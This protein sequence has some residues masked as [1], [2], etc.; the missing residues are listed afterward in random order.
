LPAISKNRYCRTPRHNCAPAYAL[1]RLRVYIG[2][3]HVLPQV[4][5]RYGQSGYAADVSS[6]Q[7][8]NYGSTGGGQSWYDASTHVSACFNELLVLTFTHCHCIIIEPVFLSVSLSV[9][10]CLSCLEMTDEY[11][12]F[13]SH[14]LTPSPSAALSLCAPVS[15]STGSAHFRSGALTADDTA[16]LVSHAGTHAGTHARTHTHTHTHTHTLTLRRRQRTATERRTLRRR[17]RRRRPSY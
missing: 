3:P 15:P 4:F 12:T 10:A 6:Y 1:V 13:L 17:T 9:L 2:A 11:F 5:S 7:S 16:A 8:Q 14:P